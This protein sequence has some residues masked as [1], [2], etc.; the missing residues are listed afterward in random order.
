M[1]RAILLV[2]S[3]VFS[4][5]CT[6][7]FALSGTTDDLKNPA[8]LTGKTWTCSGWKPIALFQDVLIDQT[9]HISD[10]S[11]ADV[12]G[13]FITNMIPQGG[14]KAPVPPGPL[15]STFKSTIT[16]R[17]PSG[18]PIFMFTQR[19]Y[20]FDAELLPDGNMKVIGLAGEAVLQ[21]ESTEPA[22]Q[23]TDKPS[24][25]S[26]TPAATGVKNRFKTITRLPEQLEII[27][28]G[29][30]IPKDIASLSG[31][32]QGSFGEGGFSI[33]STIAITSITENGVT[34]I[35][36]SAR[37]PNPGWRSVYGV[38]EKKKIIL[39]WWDR[40]VTLTPRGK[41]LFVEYEIPSVYAKGYFSRVQER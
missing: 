22:T 12:S 30:E 11:G 41:D 14:K 15:K 20:P 2:L 19:G 40:K 5:I 32:W 29:P 37:E 25:Q 8:Y 31:V 34:A 9:L 28:P 23:V 17:T 24:E 27:P 16:R 35:Y 39:L 18:L 10:V 33:A 36:S 7:G 6:G 3:V 13:E 38:V 21:Q 1:N 4:L 26:T